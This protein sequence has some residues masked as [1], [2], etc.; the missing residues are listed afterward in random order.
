MK[1]IFFIL[2][3]LTV[4]F[5]GCVPDPQLIREDFLFTYNIK[6]ENLQGINKIYLQEENDLIWF[7][8]AHQGFLSF[9]T[10]TKNWEYYDLKRGL[11]SLN[12][13]S[14]AVG[15][16][17]IWVGT[18]TGLMRMSVNKN[19]IENFFGSTNN[20]LSK[21]INSIFVEKDII[22][23]G[24]NKGVTALVKNPDVLLTVSQVSTAIDKEWIKFKKSDGLVAN[25]ISIIKA[26]K[27]R[28][29]FGT[30]SGLSI[31]NKNYQQ[32]KS[33]TKASGDLQNDFITDIIVDEP[34]VWVATLEG[35]SRFHIIFENWEQF[36]ISSG[37]PSNSII[38]IINTKNELFVLTQEGLGK[39]D[40]SFNIWR[41]ILTKPFI[42]NGDF[43]SLAVSNGIIYVGTS[44]GIY[45]STS[46]EGIFRKLFIDREEVRSSIFDIQIDKNG[47]WFS[48]DK[49][50][51]HF[52]KI[53][54][55]N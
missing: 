12:L 36:N 43:T 33:Y 45:Y 46:R 17:E 47:V 39:F 48:S 3:F 42:L 35:L 21:K 51:F 11:L 44:N 6:A 30:N 40:K 22:W 7:T 49:G 41:T 4:L 8:T 32:F 52:V 2:L 20:L 54:N 55:T 53:K 9:N 18:D 1:N 16:N 23:I 19:K 26:T 38:K 31:L 10:E 13:F 50:T 25:N 34:Y 37:L 14:F 24:T 28:I 5:T 15:D 29:Y 27:T